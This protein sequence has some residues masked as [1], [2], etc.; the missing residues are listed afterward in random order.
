MEFARVARE[1]RLGPAL[2]AH[3][4]SVS[5]TQIEPVIGFGTVIIMLEAEAL[6]ADRQVAVQTVGDHDRLAIVFFVK[7]A[8]GAVILINER[9]SAHPLVLLTDVSL[10]G[11]AA[12]R[13]ELTLLTND[14]VARLF[15]ADVTC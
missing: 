11:M 14:R 12:T 13:Y 2:M 7:I 3:L 8:P 10:L 5:E 9:I 6:D 1:S 4:S 15:L